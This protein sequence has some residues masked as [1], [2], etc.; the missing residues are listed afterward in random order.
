MAVLQAARWYI[1]IF[2]QK[3]SIYRKQLLKRDITTE[4]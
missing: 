4:Q 1:E 2:I 3:V